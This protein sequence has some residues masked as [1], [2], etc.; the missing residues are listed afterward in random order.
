MISDLFDSSPYKKI[1][2]NLGKNSENYL[3]KII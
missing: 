2:S 1:K 3:D